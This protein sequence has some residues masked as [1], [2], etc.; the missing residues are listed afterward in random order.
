MYS[1]STGSET[2]SVVISELELNIVV[3]KSQHWKYE[4]RFVLVLCQDLVIGFQAVSVN[5]RIKRY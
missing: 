1:V 5:N 2:V 4:Q 3:E